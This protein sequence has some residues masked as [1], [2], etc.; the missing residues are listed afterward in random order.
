M[1]PALGLVCIT[2][3][4]AVRF[5]AMTRARLL[6]FK[7][8]EQKTLLRQLYLENV[9]R[10]RKAVDFCVAH[11]IRL[12]RMI[13]SLFPFA[14]DDAGA[15]VLDAIR[16]AIEAEG[17]RASA[18]R[19]RIVAHPD[20]YVVLNSDQPAVVR[21]SIKI[22]KLH[23]RVLDYLQQP[24]TAWA[25]IEIHGGKSGRASEL[26][27]A[28]AGLEPKIRSR[29][30]L[31]NDERA[32]GSD[33]MLKI[34]QA[35]RVPMVFDAHHHVIHGRL[36]SYDDPSVAACV[37][38]AAKTWPNPDWQ[39]VHISNGSASFLDPRHSDLIGTMPGSY[40]RV[41]WIEV[42]AKHKE[43]AIE[44]LRRTWPPAKRSRSETHTVST[45]KTRSE[46]PSA[47]RS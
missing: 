12:Y 44:R 37:S 33:E 45:A 39:L 18:H 10:F 1:T 43:Q 15:D 46:K 32:Y 11:D 4:D 9:S 35:T 5:R 13:S 3:T 28:I 27:G 17:R 19:I 40:A 8:A 7:P 23:G 42:E 26:I 34:C 25:A 47:A 6:T 16:P 38:A 14:D 2:S 31:E 36:K 24:R 41:P 20:Q 22:L 29:L 30:V 21:N